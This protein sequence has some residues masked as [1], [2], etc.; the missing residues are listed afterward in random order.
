[1]AP[2]ILVCG[3]GGI[4]GYVGGMLTRGGADITI[5]DICESLRFACSAPSPVPRSVRLCHSLPL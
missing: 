4:G 3:C 2:R 1:M 5:V